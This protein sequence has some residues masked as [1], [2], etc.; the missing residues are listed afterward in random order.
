MADGLNLEGRIYTEEIAK[1]NNCIKRGF[2]DADPDLHVQAIFRRLCIKSNHGNALIILPMAAC[3]KT[4]LN[5]YVI[6]T[7]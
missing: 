7:S 3:S 5:Q 6:Y 1:Y 2:G 4:V